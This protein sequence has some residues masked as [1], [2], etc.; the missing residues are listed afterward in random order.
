MEDSAP[1]GDPL[2]TFLDFMY[3]NE[4][5][6]VYSPTKNPETGSWEK[7]FFE[8]PTQRLELTRHINQSTTS[9]EVYI[10]P[11]LFHAP[12]AQ[13]QS[14]K[15][16]RVL[17]T[18]F[19]GNFQGS[20]EPCPDPSLSVQS[21]DDAHIHVYWRLSERINDAR[22]LESLN[23]GITY[24]L[25]ADSSSWDCNQ[26]LRPPTTTNHKR[27]KEVTLKEV[28][29]KFYTEASFSAV[30]TVDEVTVDVPDVIPD[31]AEVILKYPFSKDASELFR[32]S[33]LAVGDR[34]TA[35]MRLGYFC[36]EMGMSDVEIYTV[37][38]NAD[39]RWGKFK[40]R[41]DRVKR[42]SDL[43]A[44][45]RI[46][47]PED[48]LLSEDFII[49]LFGFN[50]LL[51]SEI[52][53]NWAIEGLLEEKGYMLLT[54]P[55]GVGKTQFTLRTAMCLALGKDFL[56]FKMGEPRKIIMFSLEMGHASLKKFL[57]TMA[58]N[59]SDED[60]V[61]LEKNFLIIPL[62]EAW[63]LD[64]QGG[65][66]RMLN[67]LKEVRPD[68]VIIDSLG[69]TT[70]GQVSDEGTVK[71]IMD[72][73][74][75]IRNRFNIFTWWIHHNRKAQADN[76]KPNKLADVYGNQYIVNRATSVYCLWPGSTRGTIEVIP[77]KKRLDDLEDTWKIQRLSNLDF[78]RLNSVSLKAPVVVSMEDESVDGA[79]I[80]S[81]IS[82]I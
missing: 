76:K 62:G 49:P 5:G 39:D 41:T 57:K 58:D 21:S 50:S 15:S 42:L 35:L 47:H 7:N 10:A 32:S 36:A 31:V 63:Y 73:N 78:H 43:I 22:E 13:K 40:D 37:I 59:L 4:Q 2:N 65:Q 54:G 71:K 48:E 25:G 26:V 56:G 38:R 27:G 70:T 33:E 55:S 8:W 24:A 69:S 46:K 12:D 20:F 80:L 18:E 9:A 51:N 53:I 3:D 11:A 61:T 52:E 64:D 34:S 6:Y 79:T 29:L 28:N 14:F 45:V 72:F 67:I 77:L 19:D 68:G 60:L 16:S 82:D 30:P 75:R 66:E 23:R 44:K 1:V 74:D 17:W 81:G